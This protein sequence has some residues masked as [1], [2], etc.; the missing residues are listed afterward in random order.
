MNADCV[1]SADL[2]ETPNHATPNLEATSL[3]RPTVP[4]FD[5]A[6]AAGFPSPAADYPAIGLDLNQLLIPRPSSTF[7][8][9][10]AGESMLG[11][12]IHDGDLILVDRSIEARPGHA[13]VASLAGEFVLKRLRSRGGRLFLDSENPAFRSLVLP[14][15]GD[16]AIWGVVTASIRQHV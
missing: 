16:F 11:A 10:V 9:R 15:E 3:A 14:G 6:V 1:D 12:G 13:V 2:A 7:V 8:L 4:F 5:D